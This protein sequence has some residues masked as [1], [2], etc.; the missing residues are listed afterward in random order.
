MLVIGDRADINF[1]RQVTRGL[2]AQEYLYQ[3]LMRDMVTRYFT[4]V[5]QHG[6]PSI[7]V[8]HGGRV[9]TVTGARKA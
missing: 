9:I 6:A 8:V 5:I 3:P 7:E 2:G 1:Y 4:P